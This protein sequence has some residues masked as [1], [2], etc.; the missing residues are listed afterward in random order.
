MKFEEPIPDRRP[1]GL[2]RSTDYTM[3]PTLS[4]SANSI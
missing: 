3:E 2:L 1:P 4:D